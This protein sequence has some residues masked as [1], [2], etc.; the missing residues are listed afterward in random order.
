MWFSRHH[1]AILRTKNREMS[2]S[3]IGKAVGV[4]WKSA[5]DEQKRP[6]DDL[7]AEVCVTC[8]GFG[9]CYLPLIL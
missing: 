3:D 6:F 7:S 4:L 1:R 9:P 5:T 8:N 2:F